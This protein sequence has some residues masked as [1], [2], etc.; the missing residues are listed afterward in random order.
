[1][2]RDERGLA[3]AQ[4]PVLLE[5]DGLSKT[6]PARHGAKVYAVPD[7]SFSVRRGTTVGLVGESGS[8]KTT[9]GRSLLRLIEPSGG[10]ILF[11]GVDL[12]RLSRRQ[13]N[14]YRRDMQI[15]FQ[16]P[17]SSLN[18]RLRVCDILGEALNT[19]G[20]PRGARRAHRHRPRAGGRAEIYRRRRAGLGA[21]CVGT[22]AG[23]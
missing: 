7:L 5:V 3:P 1:M 4:D 21:G 2:T 8:G 20:F 17:Y 10:R 23:A 14:R 22:G 15:I 19:H 18:P 11:D 16:D 12:L 6:F 13:M 9:A